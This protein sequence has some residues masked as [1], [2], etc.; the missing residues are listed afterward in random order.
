M[1]IQLND[2]LS[3]PD[4]NQYKLHLA[5]RNQYSARPLDEF[6][7]SYSR[8]RGWNTW[9]GNRNDWTRDYVLSF[10]EFYPKEDSW[11]FGGVFKVL[12]RHKKHYD[13]E[14][15]ATFDKY[16]G[17]LIVSFYRYQGMRGRASYLENYLDQF[18]VSEIL[19]R[20]YAGESFP[21]FENIELD[22]GSLERILKDER[23]DWKAVLSNAKGVYLIGDISNGKKYVGSAYGVDGI[24]SR[25]ACY[26][27]TGHGWVDELTRIV[28]R[29][30]LKYARQ[31]FRFSVLE[32]VSPS[33]SD[34]A[35]IA[36]ENHWKR[37]LLSQKHGYNRN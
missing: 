15:V 29:R 1:T 8:W 11:L 14:E 23:D 10:M 3:I 19:P 24:W 12:A 28:K 37:V 33:M 30:G 31:N 4:P 6:L 7:V 2:L 36:R 35:V 34:E 16:V 21:G 27:G 26:I 32:I 17:R 5:C 18:K 13:L 20:P 22:F 25:W 9:K